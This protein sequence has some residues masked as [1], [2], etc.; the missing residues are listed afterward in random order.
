MKS[1]VGF[2]K[3]ELKRS[4]KGVIH[5]ENVQGEKTVVRE[6]QIEKTEALLSL[7]DILSELELLEGD[8]LVSAAARRCARRC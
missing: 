8:D 1:I 6:N 2:T 4:L 5:M 3:M 7:E